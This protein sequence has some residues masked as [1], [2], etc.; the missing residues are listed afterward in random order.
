M[1][2]METPLAMGRVNT[3]YYFKNIYYL[4]LCACTWVYVCAPCVQTERGIKSPVTGVTD[5]CEQSC[6]CWEPHP[7]TARTVR[8]EPSIQPP[9]HC[10]PQLY[11]DCPMVKV[12]VLHNVFH[13]DVC[14]HEISYWNISLAKLGNGAQDLR[15]GWGQRLLPQSH[16]PSLPLP[17]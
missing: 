12:T 10:F 6:G 8:A 4:F 3:F 14:H 17:F 1:K 9:F 11:T 13:L 5:S 7:V 2:R 16:T 15:Q